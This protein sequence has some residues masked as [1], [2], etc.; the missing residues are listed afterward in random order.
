MNIIC[1]I[2]SRGRPSGLRSMLA[3]LAPAAPGGEWADPQAG[4]GLGFGHSRSSPLAEALHFDREAGLAAVVDARLDDRAGLCD[5]LGLQRPQGAALADGELLLR[6]YRRWAGELPKHL[7]GDYAFAIW[8]ARKRVLF[9]ARDPLGV[10]PCYYAHCA[11]ARRFAFA[12][13]L[14]AVLAAPGVSD[15]LDEAVVA[16]ALTRAGLDEAER[17]F[18]KDVRKLPPGHSLTLTV[19]APKGSAVRLARHWR[20]EQA[21]AVRRPS[22]DDY[23]EEFLSLCR[24]AVAAR[25]QGADPIGAHLSGGLDSSGIT[26]LAARELRGSG[27]PPPLAFSWLPDPAG[28]PPSEVH[29]P[30]YE[31]IDAVCRQEG[32]EV[33]HRAPNAEDMVRVLRLDGARPGVQVLASEEVVQRCAAERGVRVLLSGWGGD[34]GASFNGRGHHAHLL[35]SGR[36]GRLAALGR[37]LGKGP[38]RTLADAALPLLHPNARRRRLLRGVGGFRGEPWRRRW[39][40]HP[41]LARRTHVKPKRKPRHWSMRQALLWHLSNGAL[42]ERIEGW[43]A[44]GAQHG[45]EYRYPLLDRRLLEFVLG[46]PPEQF[47]RGQWNRWLMRRALR[48]ALP[49]SILWNRSKSDPARYDPM[50]DAFANAL[51]LVRQLL[52]ERTAPPSR[53]Q[54]VDLPRLLE[55]LDADRFRAEPR[56]AAIQA[57]LQFLDF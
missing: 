39:L 19:D 5:A 12:G 37:A 48:G 2:C 45:I 20:P 13:A 54:Y 17:T 10:K 36:W 55:R 51:P 35:L 11:A 4:V 44:G 30:E 8:D 27:R 52:E 50:F 42:A 22:D 9:C 18:F 24:Q 25:V 15:E 21:A 6:A 57:A 28:K 7:F 49:A 40:A 33:L 46:L 38:L 29:A 32:L 56:W 43:A 47:L 16:R 3:A 1:G 53:A 41:A 31:R 34:Q 23:A 26:V 14:D